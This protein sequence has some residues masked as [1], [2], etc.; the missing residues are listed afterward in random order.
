MFK[1]ELNEGQLETV[2][3]VLAGREH[4]VRESVGVMD[5]SDASLALRYA[6]QISK[7]YDVCYAA[8][9]SVTPTL[10]ALNDENESRTL[11][12]MANFGGHFC[13]TLVSLYRVS[14]SGNKAKLSQAFSDVFRRYGPGSDFYDR[15][16]A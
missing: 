7:C 14:D 16:Q 3:A 13:Q 12:A 1:V 10:E 2:M 9:Y 11:N 5:S 8:F 4:G 15:E 6:D